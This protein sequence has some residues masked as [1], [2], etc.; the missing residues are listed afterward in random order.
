MV[1]AAAAC[2]SVAAALWAIEWPSQRGGGAALSCAAELDFLSRRSRRVSVSTSVQLVL[3]SVIMEIIKSIRTWKPLKKSKSAQSNKSC[4][5]GGGDSSDNYCYSEPVQ[6]AS[7]Q[8]QDNNHRSQTS[9]ASAT[10]DSLYSP[11][12]T[13]PA[14]VAATTALH[15]HKVEPLTKPPPHFLRPKQQPQ[16]MY[17]GKKQQH[18]KTCIDFSI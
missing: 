6:H 8:C 16:H 14:S 15:F 5:S 2:S 4:N 12:P 9:L 1:P 11:A 18:C 7:V 13:R 10:S 17:Q 3:D